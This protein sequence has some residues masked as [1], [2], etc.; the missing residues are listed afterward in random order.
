MNHTITQC[1]IWPLQTYNLL[2]VSRQRDITRWFKPISITETVCKH[3][4]NTARLWSNADSVFFRHGPT[5][6]ID[7][8]DCEIYDYEG[9]KFVS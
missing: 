9:Y 7:H 1:I 3:L 2:T 5:T 6:F 8:V 4:P